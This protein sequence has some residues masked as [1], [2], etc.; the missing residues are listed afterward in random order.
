MVIGICAQPLA[1][2]GAGSLQATL[3]HLNCVA[4]Q[5]EVG[6]EIGMAG[7]F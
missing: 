5:F 2:R 4:C 3:E 1:A 6:V 7:L